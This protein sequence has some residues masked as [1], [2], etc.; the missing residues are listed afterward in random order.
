MPAV[1]NAFLASQSRLSVLFGDARLETGGFCNR[2]SVESTGI[3]AQPR[4]A[5]APIGNGRGLGE[6][7]ARAGGPGTGV[8][9]SPFLNRVARRGQ[10]LGNGDSGLDVAGA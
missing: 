10:S 5:V 3:R 7:P 1:T 8:R 2:Q 4:F 9:G 6:I